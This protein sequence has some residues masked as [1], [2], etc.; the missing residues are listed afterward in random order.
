MSTADFLYDIGLVNTQ[1]LM[2]FLRYEELQRGV[3]THNRKYGADKC[4][5]CDQL[6]RVYGWAE[7]TIFEDEVV[8]SFS[9]VC[10]ACWVYHPFNAGAD[11]LKEPP[12][13]C[14]FLPNCYYSF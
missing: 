9:A 11:V 14:D 7:Y 12:V 2:C 8:R 1:D 3:A 6:V 5:N 13:H 10:K 4:M